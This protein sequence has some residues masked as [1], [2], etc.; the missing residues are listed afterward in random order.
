MLLPSAYFDVIIPRL[1]IYG[2]NYYFLYLFAVMLM[3]MLINGD[4]LILLL[5]QCMLVS[6]SDDVFDQLRLH[7][8]EK[9][10][11]GNGE[12]LFDVGVGAGQ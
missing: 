5:P 7:L 12:T 4:D 1:L 9:I 6:P 10:C 11:D 8:Q 2:S 3:M